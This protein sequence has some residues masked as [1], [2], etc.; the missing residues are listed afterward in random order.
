MKV[1]TKNQIK[2]LCQNKKRNIVVISR[3]PRIFRPNEHQ[4][5]LQTSK[6]ARFPDCNFVCFCFFCRVHDASLLC[7]SWPRNI[8][9]LNI[10]KKLY[11]QTNCCRVLQFHCPWCITFCSI[12]DWWCSFLITYA[13]TVVSRMGQNFC[14][15]FEELV[16]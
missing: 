11:T 2:N 9:R 4:L 14:L 13:N 8:L 16:F 1:K 12:I 6:Y 10:K 5:Y 7:T 3:V 15:K